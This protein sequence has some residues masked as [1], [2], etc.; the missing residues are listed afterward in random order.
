MILYSK[1]VAHDI[2]LLSEVWIFI[3]LDKKGYKVE[4]LEK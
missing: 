4:C 1:S 3:Y 2:H